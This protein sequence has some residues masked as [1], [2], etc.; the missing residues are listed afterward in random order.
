MARGQHTGFQ[1]RGDDIQA[2]VMLQQVRGKGH[3]LELR[4]R[5]GEEVRLG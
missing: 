1:T 5:K 3:C 2:V 4:L